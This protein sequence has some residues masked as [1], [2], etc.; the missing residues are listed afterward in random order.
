MKKLIFVVVMILLTGISFGQTLQKGTL[1]G[2]HSSFPVP[3]PDVTMN[4]CLS[5]LKD[6]YFPEYEKNFTGS[7]CYI[8]K[9]IRG[10]CTDC[11]SFL[12][13][14][15]SDEARNKYWNADNTLTELG[16]AAFEKMKSVDS[17]MNKFG[18]MTDKFTDWIIQ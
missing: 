16:K 17:E 4:Q 13:I 5:F 11:L 15:P 14:F 3:N 1:I 18:K 2:F 12:I 8:L 6:K 7:K 9:S 10:E